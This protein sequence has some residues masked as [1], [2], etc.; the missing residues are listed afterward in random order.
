MWTPSRAGDPAVQA[1]WS[2]AQRLAISPSGIR[3]L[4]RAISASD[5]R[6]TLPLIRVPTLVAAKTD[7]QIT[8]IEHCRFLAEHIPG[9]RFVELPG[10]DH[11]PFWDDPPLL[12]DT[13]EEFLTGAPHPVE[14]DRRLAT[15][16]FVDICASTER[17]ADVGDRQW[18]RTLD[19]VDAMVQRQV[20]RSGGRVIKTLGDGALLVFDGPSRAIRCA[21]A[22]RD[23]AT[24]YGLQMRVGVHTGEIELRDGDVAG[25]AVHLAARVAAR[26]GVG[27]VL[28]SR[29]VVDL[30]AGSGLELQDRGNHDLKGIDTAWQLFAAG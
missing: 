20:D 29:T 7:D 16:V 9:A 15:V 12:L 26:A 2:R 17:L 30:V 3:E 25:I 5:V 8:P 28:V 18:H 23:G 14:T 10:A 4:V 27:E 11:V 21:Q 13:V 1:W 24:A 19:D 6:A 22:I